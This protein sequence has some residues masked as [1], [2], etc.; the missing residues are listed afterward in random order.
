MCDGF[1]FSYDIYILLSNE[2]YGLASHCTLLAQVIFI[3]EVIE[4]HVLAPTWLYRARDVLSLLV[5]S[6]YNLPLSACNAVVCLHC[7]LQVLASPSGR[8]MSTSAL[9]MRRESPPKTAWSDRTTS[10]CSSPDGVPDLVSPTQSGSYLIVP[11]SQNWLQTRAK[12]L[13]VST[14]SLSCHRVGLE[15]F[16]DLYASFICLLSMLLC[17]CFA[18]VLLLFYLMIDSCS[19]QSTALFLCYAWICFLTHHYLY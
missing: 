18:A 4:T 19:L 6:P 14:N 1:L 2:N 8:K 5:F 12:C 11:R 9:S 10:W 16:S 13:S 17:R 7:L 3:P 15:L